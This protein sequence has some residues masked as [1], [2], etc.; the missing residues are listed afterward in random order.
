MRTARGGTSSILTEG[1]ASPFARRA[2]TCGTGSRAVRNC[3]TGIARGCVGCAGGIA[4][5]SPRTTRSPPP[6][7]AA[8]ERGASSRPR[9]TERIPPTSRQGTS[10]GTRTSVLSIGDRGRRQHGRRASP[11]IECC[12]VL[13]PLGAVLQW[14]AVTVRVARLP[15][16]ERSPSACPSR[17][18]RRFPAFPVDRR[19]AEPGGVSSVWAGMTESRSVGWTRDGRQDGRGPP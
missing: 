13:E 17:S 3:A 5:G 18:V 12:D 1:R 9:P 10:P 11:G 15:G 2:K 7:P 8:G 19:R 16:P 4:T 6:L 14:V